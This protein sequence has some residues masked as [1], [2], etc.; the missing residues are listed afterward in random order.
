MYSDPSVLMKEKMIYAVQK[1]FLEWHQHQ[2]QILRS[3]DGS[4]KWGAKQV[5]G[6]LWEPMMKCFE[7]ISDVQVLED[8]GFSMSVLP[9]Y[10]AF[11][12]DIGPIAEQDEYAAKFVRF[13]LLMTSK[14]IVR[15]LSAIRGWPRRRILLLTDKAE[16]TLQQLKTDFESYEALD[17]FGSTATK[18]LASRSLFK[19]I[20][21]QQLV[22]IAKDWVSPILVIPSV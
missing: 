1:P 5:Y 18:K 4:V 19:M 22:M 7:Q 9:E 10:R 16:D 3:V 13:S 12:K 6:E 11:P 20:I 17:K 8:I 15:Q 2:N 14:R 21:N